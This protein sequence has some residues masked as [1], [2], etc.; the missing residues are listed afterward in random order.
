MTDSIKSFHQ[1]LHRWYAQHGRCELPWRNTADPYAIYVSEIMLQQTQV[2]TVLERYYAPFLKRFPTLTALAKAPQ[3]DVMKA[4][5]GLGYYSRAANLHK[6]AKAAGGTLP[7]TVDALLALP[8][9]GKNTAHAVAAFAFGK[10]V[11]VME[12]NVKRTLCRIFAIKQPSPDMLWEKAA[13]LL[14]PKN[15]YDYNQAMMD[16][17]AMVCTRRHPQCGL[18]P[19]NAICEGKADPEVYP[20]AV[21][22]KKAPKRTKWLVVKEN[23]KGEIYLKE[24]TTKFL[25]GL[26]GFLEV[27][28]ATVLKNAILLGG[29]KQV[30]SHFRLEAEVWKMKDKGT[31]KNWFTKTAA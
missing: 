27:E 1:K 13:L 23:H 17:G 8:G 25:G 30:Y 28:P 4:W 10:K 18:C 2:K 29:V 12:A 24:R 7:Q 31:G 14:D 15:S 16:I 11:P 21:L 9:I 20:A 6:A 3:R 26:Y 19:A 22:K 5:E